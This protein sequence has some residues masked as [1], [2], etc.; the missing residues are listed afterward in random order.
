MAEKNTFKQGNLQ[1]ELP[2]DDNLVRYS[3]FAIVSHSPEELVMDFARMLPGKDGAKVVSRVVM[4]PRNA[5][6][7]MRALVTNIENFEKKFGEIS[8]PEKP[9]DGMGGIQ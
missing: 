6:M 5:K 2:N 8:M 9:V 7:F 3:N 1:V 4:T